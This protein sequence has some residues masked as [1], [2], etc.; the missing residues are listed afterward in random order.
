MSQHHP[1]RSDDRS[2][3]RV[4]AAL[5]AGDDDRSAPG[6]LAALRAADD[7]GSLVTEYG[8]LAVLGATVTGLAI[9]WASGGAIWELF[10]SVLTKAKAIVGA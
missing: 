2:A 7:D 6:V 5:R 9:K 8:L 4:L 10:G 1:W 3:P